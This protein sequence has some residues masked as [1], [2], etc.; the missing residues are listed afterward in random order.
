MIERAIAEKYATL[1]TQRAAMP[2]ATREHYERTMGAV[3]ELV[4]DGKTL[5]WDNRK[6]GVQ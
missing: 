4:P 3:L 1:R 6:L 2:A 5:T